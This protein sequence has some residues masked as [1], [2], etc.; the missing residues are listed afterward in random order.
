MLTGSNFDC[1]FE[2]TKT[3][4]GVCSLDLGNGKLSKNYNKISTSGCE[5]IKSALS[6]NPMLQILSLRDNGLTAQMVRDL[7]TGIKLNKNLL[8]LDLSF[9]DLSSETVLNGLLESL[10]TSPL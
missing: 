5:A 6:A 7:S 10:S 8:S 3:A 9:S 4:G 2:A 1:L